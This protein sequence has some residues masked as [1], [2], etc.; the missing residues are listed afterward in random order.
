MNFE[1]I[2]KLKSKLNE[3]S[4]RG[5][6]KSHRLNNTGI[7]KTLEDEMDIEENNLPEGDFKIG[8]LPVELK[9]QR[10][11][12]SSRVTLSTKEPTWIL[13]KKEVIN[14]TG[15][16]DVKERIGLKITL[17]TLK[18]NNKG[19]KLE[20]SDNK[21]FI[22][23]ERLGKVC[24]FEIDKLMEIIKKKIGDNL[25][26]VLAEVKKE[27][28]IEFFHYSEAILFS[29]FY[30]EKFK[31]LINSGQIIWEFRLH[32]KPSGAIRDHGSGFRINRKYLSN[33]YENKVTLI[34]F[35]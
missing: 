20:I 6:I 10:K 26:F 34:P 19:Y 7:G 33:L 35:E 29:N 27:K 8:E 1:N 25:L 24:F 16:K 11:T 5:F 28:D 12:A 9:T 14:K 13:N 17:N 22:V 2:D 18:F 30:E 4:G 21:I 31:E 15:Y 32:L 3:I 23:H